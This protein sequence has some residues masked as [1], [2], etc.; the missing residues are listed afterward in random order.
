MNINKKAVSGSSKALLRLPVCLWET[1][2]AE[3][4]DQLQFLLFILCMTVTDSDNGLHVESRPS[5]RYHRE[6]SCVSIGGSWWTHRE[7]CLCIHGMETLMICV[8]PSYPSDTDGMCVYFICTSIPAILVENVKC[9]DLQDQTWHRVYI[10]KCCVNNMTAA[11]I[12][13]LLLN[14]KYVYKIE[15]ISHSI[16]VKYF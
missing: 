3:V 1:A 11:A 2:G 12:F 7:G 9:C 16:H 14:Y 8:C 5:R 6:L 4:C 15:M 10:S 13:L